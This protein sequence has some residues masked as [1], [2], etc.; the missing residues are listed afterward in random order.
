MIVGVPSCVKYSDIG[1]YHDVIIMHCPL[2]IKHMLVRFVV[3]HV[4]YVALV[5]A[6]IPANLQRR[7]FC[8]RGNTLCVLDPHIETYVLGSFEGFVSAFDKVTE[9][10]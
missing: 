7:P 9:R 10:K 6:T 3:M 1:A 5:I 8:Q 4:H 2:F